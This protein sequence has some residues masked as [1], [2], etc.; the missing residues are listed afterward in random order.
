MTVANFKPSLT[1][2]LAYEGGYVNHPRDPGGATNRGV[3]QKVYDNY[4]RYN[5]RPVQSVRHISDDEV[6]DIYKKQY[7]NSIRLDRFPCGLDYAVFDFGVNSGPARAIRYLQ[8][9]LDIGVDGIVGLETLTAVEAAARKDE[10][11]LIAQYCA[12]RFAFV[13]KLST[14]DVFGKGWTRRIMGRQ[15]GYQ[16]E[17]TGVIDHA[18]SMAKRD[19]TYLT[20]VPPSIGQVYGEQ[21]GKAELP[22]EEIGFVQGPEAKTIGDVKSLLSSDN[23]KLAAIIG[24]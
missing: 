11:A 4:R 1:L 9:Q 16:A 6:A 19:P 24:G 5:G 3:T 17:D 8:Q 10:E 2:T 18:V 13:S 23:D 12:N 21:N 7:W 22:I 14:F 20:T 15:L